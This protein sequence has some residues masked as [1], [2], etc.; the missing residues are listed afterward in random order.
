MLVLAGAIL[1]ALGVASGAFL[2]LAP[3]GFVAAAPG[4]TLWIL[5]PL[6]TVAG[7]LLLAFP[8]RPPA[9]VLLSRIAGGVLLVL[10]LLAALGLFAAASGTLKATDSTSA[11]WYVLG[12]G[13]LL[14]VAGLSGH[15]SAGNA[16]AAGATRP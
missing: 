3:F 16:P 6:F 8:S 15:R 4:L 5:F 9:V 10:A 1:L 7:Y 2:A 14:G 12:F 13:L 11:L